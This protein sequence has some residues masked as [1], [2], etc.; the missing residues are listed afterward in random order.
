[1]AYIITIRDT[2]P[3]VQSCRGPAPGAPGPGRGPA[4]HWATR[5]GSEL[6]RWVG[7]H[8][9]LDGKSRRPTHPLPRAEEVG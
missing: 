9:T 1:M 7:F 3:S 8:A 5:P 2:H 6:T 4:R